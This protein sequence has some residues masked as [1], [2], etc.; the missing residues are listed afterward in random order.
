MLELAHKV[1]RK[2]EIEKFFSLRKEDIHI[3]HISIENV[4]KTWYFP[5]SIEKAQ[6]VSF[7]N[8]KIPKFFSFRG[9]AP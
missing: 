3:F 9:Q 6:N 7:A 4:L 2:L 1:G 5:N 8:M